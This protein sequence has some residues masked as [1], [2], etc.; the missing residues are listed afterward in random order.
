MGKR[1][2]QVITKRRNAN[3]PF[4]TENVKTHSEIIDIQLKTTGYH[5]ENQIRKIDKY[6]A[7]VGRE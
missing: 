1:Y 5:F 2:E 7:V 6:L 4:S 3:G